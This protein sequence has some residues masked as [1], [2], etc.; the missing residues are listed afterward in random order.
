[1]AS[2]SECYFYLFL[3]EWAKNEWAQR[4]EKDLVQNVQNSRKMR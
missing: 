1:M 3:A 4:T 2:L